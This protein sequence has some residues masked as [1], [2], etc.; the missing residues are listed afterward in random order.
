[1]FVR[2]FAL[3]ALLTLFACE[4]AS[5]LSYA[6]HDEDN[7]YFDYDNN[8][9]AVQLRPNPNYVQCE[10]EYP[11]PTEGEP[12]E[13]LDVY[14]ILYK[15]E[16]YRD[17]GI[18][19]EIL[20]HGAEERYVTYI[21]E[22]EELWFLQRGRYSTSLPNNENVSFEPNAFQDATDFVGNFS[23]S[24][25]GVEL[26]RATLMR[27][28]DRELLSIETQEDMQMNISYFNAV[29]PGVKAA[30]SAPLPFASDE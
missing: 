10:V 24:C 6:D 12:V 2:A 19:T 7:Q 5:S 11:E 9:V 23:V 28:F 29:S 18:P 30:R 22:D 1:M 25:A 8:V 15:D 16:H 17:T 14:E 26:S 3:L 13:E 20:S 27:P 4:D 21:G